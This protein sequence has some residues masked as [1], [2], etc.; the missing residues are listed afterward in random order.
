MTRTDFPQF[1]PNDFETLRGQT[2]IVLGVVDEQLARLKA[3]VS[4]YESVEEVFR[5][6]IQPQAH[7]LAEAMLCHVPN[8]DP[9]IM[10]EIRMGD[11]RYFKSDDIMMIDWPMSKETGTEHLRTISE[12]LEALVGYLPKS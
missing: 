11:F 8:N 4:N 5:T 10:I 9:R 1:D 6:E 2:A 7:G 12:K 3:D